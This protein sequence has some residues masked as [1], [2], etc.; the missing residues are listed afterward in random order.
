MHKYVSQVAHDINNPVGNCLMYSQMMEELLADLAENP[1][2]DDIAQ[3]REFNNNIKMALNNLT[4]VLDAWVMAH[5]I[6][7][8]EYQPE[9]QP[10]EPVP[11]LET[12]LR[13]IRIYTDR[14]KLQLDKQ[15][16][17]AGLKV[18]SDPKIIKR[19]FE[20]MSML[21]VMFAN[22]QDVLRFSIQQSETHAV[23]NMEDSYTDPREALH[24]R[25]TGEEPW[26]DG[27]V[28]QEGILKPAGY[29]L[30]FCGVALKLLNA[31]PEVKQS[32]L[33]GLHFSFKLPLLK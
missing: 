13:E 10:A 28:L 21:M 8:D 25:F 30:K 12:A 15:W 31:E 16:T 33:G 24:N 29:G 7:S 6:V 18:E 11:Y 1:G 9:M 22:Q 20:S 27:E 14:K 3:A 23:I 26:N 5:K 32:Q 19:V 4:G 17:D 2:E